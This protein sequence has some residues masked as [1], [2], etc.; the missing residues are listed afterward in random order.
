MIAILPLGGGSVRIVSQVFFIHKGT[1]TLYQLMLS[2]SGRASFDDFVKYVSLGPTTL[3]GPTCGVRDQG[4]A[5]YT[6][7][8]IL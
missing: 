6:H 1:F 2:H 3:I 8:S 4:C 5:K 7:A